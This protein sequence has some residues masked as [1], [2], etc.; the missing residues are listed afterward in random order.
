MTVPAHGT[1]R[2]R[3]VSAWFAE[4]SLLIAAVAADLLVWSNDNQLRS[5]GY[6]PPWLIPAGSTATPRQ[7]RIREMATPPRQ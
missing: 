4:C 3:A 5:G 7:P 1:N 6:A 2:W